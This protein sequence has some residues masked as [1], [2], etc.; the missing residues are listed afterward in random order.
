MDFFDKLAMVAFVIS[1][2]VIIAG[3]V[4]ATAFG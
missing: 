4:I 2:G 3:T 1:V